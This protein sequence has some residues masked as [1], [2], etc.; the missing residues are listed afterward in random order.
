[1]L[2]NNFHSEA[3]SLDLQEATS[4]CVLTFFVQ[5]PKG[6]RGVGGVG[7]CVGRTGSLVCPLIRTGIPSEGT[8]HD[9]I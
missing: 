4:C 7:V 5:V 9:L 3:L 6:Q 1:M 2:A 8:P